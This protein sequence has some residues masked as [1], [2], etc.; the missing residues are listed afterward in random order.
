MSGESSAGE[1]TVRQLA[2]DMIRNKFENSIYSK[3][4]FVNAKGK[5]E[6]DKLV[7]QWK[8]KQGKQTSK[9][10]KAWEKQ[11]R[12]QERVKAKKEIKQMVAKHKEDLFRQKQNKRCWEEWKKELKTRPTSATRQRGVRPAWVNTLDNDEEGSIGE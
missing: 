12:K 4:G 10:F 1:E 5:D 3:V 7:K 9:S 2:L 6:Q 8:S 11:K